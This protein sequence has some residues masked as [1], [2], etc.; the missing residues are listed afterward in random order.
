MKKDTLTP[1]QVADLLGV[2]DI[3]R[4]N[5]EADIEAQAVA[6]KNETDRVLLEK[7]ETCANLIESANLDDVD[8]GFVRRKLMELVGRL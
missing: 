3:D 8:L 7:I 1:E 5:M 4:K 2:A 6:N